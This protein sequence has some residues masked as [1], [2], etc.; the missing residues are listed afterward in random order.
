MHQ[1][2]DEL[3]T[4]VEIE[5][6]NEERSLTWWHSR[7]CDVVQPQPGVPTQL[8]QECDPRMHQKSEAE[9]SETKGC[10]DRRPEDGLVRAIE[11]R[12]EIKRDPMRHHRPMHATGET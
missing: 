6:K 9:E 8:Q 11:E 12:N 5:A 4:E 10:N 7:A 2:F 3:K 1:R